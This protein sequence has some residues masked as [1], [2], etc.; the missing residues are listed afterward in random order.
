[1]SLTPKMS[2]YFF[3]VQ[4]N[5]IRRK[6]WTILRRNAMSQYWFLSPLCVIWHDVRRYICGSFTAMRSSLRWWI[7]PSVYRLSILCFKSRKIPIQS[8]TAQLLIY[9]Q[10]KWPQ[11]FFLYFIL[12]IDHWRLWQVGKVV[13]WKN[14][15]SGD[16]CTGVQRKTSHFL[17]RQKSMGFS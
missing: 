1:M 2:V 15:T 12:E 16:L 4:I 8:P 10:R 5:Y 11:S 7:H 14:S 13:S 3:S 17:L 6:Y 9:Q